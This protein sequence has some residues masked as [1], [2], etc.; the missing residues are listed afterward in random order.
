MVEFA[1][2]P[3]RFK[4]FATL[5]HENSYVDVGLIV[6]MG[7]VFFG[8]ALSGDWRWDDPQILLHLHQFSILSDFIDPAVWQQ[9]SPANLTPWLIFSFEI[10]LILFGVNPSAFYLHQVLALI[11]AAVA[12][13]AL[14]RLWVGNYHALFGALLLLAGAPSFVV[15]EQL[16]TRQ[17]VEGLVFCLL[18][19]F[20]FVQFLRGRRNLLLLLAAVFV[21]GSGLGGAFAGGVA[22]G[23]SQDTDSGTQVA[24][25]AGQQAQTAPGRQ[26]LDQLRQRLQGSDVS[27]EE[28][29]EIRQQF[30]GAG[31]F[32]RGGGG[33]SGDGG[34]GGLIGTVEGISEGILTINTPHGPLQAT[35]GADTTIQ[36][37]EEGTAEDLES[38]TQ[39]IIVGE[40]NE[41]GTVE[42]SSVTV[43]PGTGG[44]FFFGGGQR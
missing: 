38:G 13:Y 31:G 41:D 10:D 18:A 20:C 9:F 37:F 28:L 40:R 7:L 5:L 42:A 32:G 19:V 15:I 34:R 14:L 24:A 6:L 25:A 23:Q 11:A 44:G 29:A 22:V 17:Y 2:S 43:T 8:G 30:Q 1:Q 35:I 39:V 3:G 36:V 27:D 12:L 26:T 33:F 16:M 21:L 4:S